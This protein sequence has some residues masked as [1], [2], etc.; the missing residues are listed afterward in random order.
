MNTGNSIKLHIADEFSDA[1]GARYITDGPKSGQE[2]Y[3]ELL[4]PRYESA[5]ARDIKLLVNLD[6][7]WGYA[8]S[9]LSESFGR[10][11]REFSPEDV[12]ARLVLVSDEEPHLIDYIFSLIATPNDN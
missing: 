7:S 2:F 11:S 6:G 4:K 3:E 9:F 1:P 10:L 8:S 5:V 12:S